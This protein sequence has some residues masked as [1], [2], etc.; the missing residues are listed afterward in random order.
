MSVR[1]QVLDA[2]CE[3]NEEVRENQ[4]KD[5]LVYGIITS[6]DIVSMMM[7]L[8]DRFDIEIGA[9]FVTP[10]NFRTVDSVVELIERII[11]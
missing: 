1:E 5:L 11:D 6:F 7:E 10:E 2:L 9:E 4:D 8:E 3:V